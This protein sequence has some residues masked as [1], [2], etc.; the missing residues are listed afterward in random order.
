MAYN[1]LDGK[2]ITNADFVG[3]LSRMP[4]TSF[5]N[6]NVSTHGYLIDQYLTTSSVVHNKQLLPAVQAALKRIREYQG[7]TKVLSHESQQ[8]LATLQL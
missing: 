8:K 3:V 4:F 1:H 2:N 6:E 5:E 7:E